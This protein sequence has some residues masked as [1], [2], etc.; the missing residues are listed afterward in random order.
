VKLTPNI[1]DIRTVAR[2]GKRGGAD[3]LAAIN[4]ISSIT[5]IDLDIGSAAQCGRQN[6]ARRLLWTCGQAHR[7]QHGSAGHVRF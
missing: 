2:A 6:L 4:T 7:A 1:T 5:G 3:G